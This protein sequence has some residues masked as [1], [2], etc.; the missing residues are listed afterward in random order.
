MSTQGL[1]LRKVRKILGITQEDFARKL[2]LTVNQIDLAENAS[3]LDDNIFSHT[4]LKKMV[5]EFSINM[6][7]ILAGIGSP[8]SPL[9]YED[10]KAELLLEIS[11]K[12]SEYK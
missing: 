6:N 11:D 3:G 9:R 2:D 7:Y 4:V 1:R 8:F 10:V 5:E 12:L